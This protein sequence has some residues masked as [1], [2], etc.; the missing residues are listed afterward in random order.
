M[1]NQNKDKALGTVNDALDLAAFTV[2]GVRFQ[3]A[4]KVYHFTAASNLSVKRYDWV[5]V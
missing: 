3:L 1:E 2:V 4:G 5:V